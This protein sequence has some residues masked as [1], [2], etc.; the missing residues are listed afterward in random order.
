[1]PYDPYDPSMLI[2]YSPVFIRLSPFTLRNPL[3]V[4]VIG[5]PIHFLHSPVSTLHPP[6]SIPHPPSSILHPPSSI[7]HPPSSIPHPFSLHSPFSLLFVHI[8]LPSSLP[9]PPSA[10]YFRL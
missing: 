10:F 4:F 9:L 8:Y 6:S 2:T 1:M 5:R 3:S 7:L